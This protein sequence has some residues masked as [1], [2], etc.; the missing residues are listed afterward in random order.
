MK[1]ITLD[2]KNVEPFV[3]KEQIAN[4]RNEA[5]NYNKALH[6]G[7]GEGNDFLGW[8]NLPSS[9]SQEFLDDIKTTAAELS[10]KI[11]VAVVIGIGGSY[12]GAKACPIILRLIKRCRIIRLSCLPG[13][14]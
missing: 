5:E 14:I 3:S 9:T 6:E 1:N 4:H 12:L 13:K 2:L 7:T 10:K 8:L 11:D